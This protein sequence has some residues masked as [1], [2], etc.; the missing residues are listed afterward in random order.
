MNRFTSDNTRVAIIG[1]GNIGTQFACM[2]ASKGYRVNLHTSRPELFDGLLEIVDDRCSVTKGRLSLVSSDMREVVQSCGIIFVTH[3]AFQLEAVSDRILPYIGEGTIICVLPGTGGAEYAFKKC[4]D[5]GA[6]LCG[7]QRV[8]SVARLEEYGKRVRC[9]GVRNELY[10][11]SIPHGYAD[12][13]A[14]FLSDIWGIPCNILPNY[15][16]VTLTPS[17]PILHTT[18][19]RTLFSEYHD[20]YVYDS[21]PRFYGDWD[22]ESSRRLLTVDAELQ[23]MCHMLSD[24]DLRSV[25]SLRIHYESDTEEEIT[26]KLRSISS[27]NRLPSPMKRHAGGWVPDFDS[28]YFL[29]DFPYGLAIL[30][31]LAYIL[32]Y[33]APTIGD[34]MD[35]YIRVTGNQRL[36]SFERYGIHTVDDIYEYYK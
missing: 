24:I 27:L 33:M 25:K 26:H 3:P 5:A 30:E 14:V 23:D 22:I 10:L 17:N 9:E 28:R 7:L 18:R 21:N 20:G 8:P 2:I 29:A 1:G 15:L 6:I 12:G 36:F 31:E 11:A 32:G 13:V 4:I 16:S 35:W 34:T 19:L